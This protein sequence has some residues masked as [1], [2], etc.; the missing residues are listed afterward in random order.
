MFSQIAE[1][2]GE[3]LWIKDTETDSMIFINSLYEQL[4]GR[5][6]KEIYGDAKSFMYNVHP[7]DRKRVED[8]YEFMK[9]SGTWR[10]DEEFRIIREDGEILWFKSRTFPVRDEDGSIY[11]S[12]GVAENITPKKEMEKK[13]SDLALIDDL[14]GI[15]NRRYFFSKGDEE[16]SRAKRYKHEMSVMML[17][18]DYFKKVNDSF[19]HHYGDLTLKEFCK[20]CTN[21]LRKTDIFGRIGG[22]EFAVILPETDEYSCSMIAERLKQNVEEMVTPAE[23]GEIRITTSIGISSLRKS[24]SDFEEIVKRADKALYRA[25]DAG[26]NKVMIGI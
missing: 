1:N 2:I 14:T 19:G 23:N 13:L 24:D 8:A 9:S 18:I 16:F 5:S 20:S 7:E 25:K 12:V 3:I 15:Y 21:S 6:K 11:R 4:W 17:D 26:R 22:E 10:F